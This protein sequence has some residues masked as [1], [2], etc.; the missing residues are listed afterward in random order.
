VA[1]S[2]VFS[3]GSR[4]RP[5]LEEQRTTS[6]L[7]M[8]TRRKFLKTAA[9]LGAGVVASQTR[10][11]AATPSDLNA[12]AQ[13]PSG[14]DDKAAAGLEARRVPDTLDLAEHGRLGLNA[15]L[16]PLDPALDYENGGLTFLDEHPAYMIHWSSMFSGVMPKYVEALPL[17]RLMSGSQ[18]DIDVQNGFMEAMLRNMADDGLV[19][20]RARP[21][22]PWNAGL[23]HGVE[24]WDEDYANI[25]GN[26]R[27]LVGLTY[28]HQ[29]TGEPK[30]QALA[31]KTA[32]RIRELAIVRNGVAYYPQTG[33]G[34]DFS[35]PRKS[36][37]TTTRPPK[38]LDEGCEGS[39]LFYQFQQ[40]RGFAHY[41]VLTG[42]ERVMKLSRQ[43]VD[44]GLRPYF[45]GAENDMHPA[46]GAER[47]HFKGHFHGTLAAIRGIL[48]YAL[49]ADDARLKLFVRD[50]YDWTRQQGVHRLGLCPG[51]GSTEGCTIADTVGLAVAL[52]DAGLGDYWDD[53]EQIVRNGLR[54]AQFT[55]RDEM[56]RVSEAGPARVKVSP[57]GGTFY[58]RLS[59]TERPVF[60]GQE[61]TDRVI[62]RN[63]GA[64]GVVVRAHHLKAFIMTCCTANGNQALYYAWEGIVRSRG[65]GKAEVNMWLNRRSPWCDVWSW[66]PYQGRLVV[67]NKGLRRIAVRKPGWA[68]Q[69]TVRCRLD[70]REAAPD[71]LGN[72]LVFAGLKGNERIEVRVPVAVDKA[73]YGVVDLNDR[74]AHAAVYACEF[75]GHTATHVVSLGNADANGPPRYRIFRRDAMRGDEAPMKDTPHYVHPEKLV[76]WTVL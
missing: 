61:V 54:E 17:L 46:M 7:S 31:K 18:A 12:T 57:W 62:D 55:D 8:T 26:G 34:N 33:L 75:K 21:D 2:A 52:T 67:Q 25:A 58:D 40:L 44:F 60:K 71:W 42:D 37:W 39:M 3:A 20:D 47:G 43:L 65:D 4:H 70:G 59:E 53:V 74:A 68:R 16:S 51:G 41:Y 11:I 28:W 32:D 49:V 35:Y 48:D 66:L 10:A 45:W 76:Q 56:V 36:G 24:H 14:E 1:V 72:R 23:G 22:R 38:R 6:K 69:A 13:S 29:W 50:A 9:I 19:Y 63:L 73:E 64:F 15:I 30:W 27:L 5:F